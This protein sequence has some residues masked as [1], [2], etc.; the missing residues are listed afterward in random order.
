MSS[1]ETP[2][3]RSGRRPG[4]SGTREA[5]AT[6]ALEQFAR[7]GYERTTIR[8]IALQAGVDPALVMH[9][10]GSK[11]QL[12]EASM[13]MSMGVPA[14]LD[15]LTSG[16]PGEIGHRLAV[17]LMTVMDDPVAGNVL[18]GRIRTGTTDP[19]AA[20][21]L[22]RLVVRE[23]LLPLA[24]RIGADHAEVRAGLVGSQVVGLVHT[25]WIVGI[26]SIVELSREQVVAAIGPTFQRYLTEPLGF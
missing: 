9:Y 17:F 23:M 2:K 13:D 7:L 25:R 18:I 22:R 19:A 3:R 12:F 6:A 15:R 4:D 11:E 1:R 10:F 16:D 14:V 8:S 20:E 21:L 26:D 5:I 24:E